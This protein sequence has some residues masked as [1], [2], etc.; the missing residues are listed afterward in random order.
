[1]FL[2]FYL[3]LKIDSTCLIF[4]SVLHGG[5]TYGLADPLRFKRSSF[6]ASSSSN[7]L[8]DVP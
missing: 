7:I 1:M 3:I 2:V 5:L 4:I 6:K 8:C